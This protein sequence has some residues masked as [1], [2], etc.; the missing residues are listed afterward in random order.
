MGCWVPVLFFSTVCPFELCNHLTD[1]D[2]AGLEVIEFILKL[3]IK[4]NDLL[5]EDT[6]SQAA[7]R[8]A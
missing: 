1:K 5:L 6:C 8:Y 7:N 3:K 4:R 2:G